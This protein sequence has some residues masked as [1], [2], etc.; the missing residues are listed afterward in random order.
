G[1]SGNR[2]N[3][4]FM[5]AEVLAGRIG[6]AF[7]RDRSRAQAATGQLAGMPVIVAKPMAFMNLTGPPLA[8]LAGFYKIPADRI[9]VI[10][11]DLHLPFATVRLKRGGGA[12]GHNGLRSVTPAPGTPA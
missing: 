1:Y 9:V 12:G 2:H 4:G 11:D 5:V 8:A 6:A 7:R 10:H 3:V